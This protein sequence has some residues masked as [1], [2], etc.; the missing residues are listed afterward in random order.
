MKALFVR[1]PWANM[2]ASGEK[3]IEARTWATDYRGDLLI[4]SCKWPQIEAAG[5]ALCVVR[6]IDCVPMR[7]EHEAAAK[8]AYHPRAYA[9]LLEDV[10]LISRFPVKG[11]LG[12]FEV[13][14]PEFRRDFRFERE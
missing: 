10:R 7:P 14:P 4:C 8:C 2:I 12:L 3:T 9:W 1:Q 5:F 6:L 11:R 13:E